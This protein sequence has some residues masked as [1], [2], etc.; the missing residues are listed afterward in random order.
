VLPT[1]YARCDDVVYLHGAA[2]NR[3]LKTVAAGAPIC[4]TVTLLDGIVLARSAFHHSMNY[5]SVVLFGVGTAVED[6]DE[7]LR[8]L[9]AI[10]DHMA[11]GRSADARP[12]TET[13]LRATAVVRLPVDEAS[14]KVRSGG[15]LDND[16]DMA[17]PIWA[18]VIPCG[19]VSG[20]A[21]SDPDLPESIPTPGYVADPTPAATLP[22]PG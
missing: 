13:E 12:P 7:K 3:M 5:R 22:R 16:E 19:L 18:G 11:A 9:L 2:A 1:A 14:A 15:P 4:V 8:A 21:V 10:V 6:P 17:L 20:P